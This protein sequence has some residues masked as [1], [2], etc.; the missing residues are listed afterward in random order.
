MF[1]VLL[2]FCFEMDWYNNTVYGIQTVTNIA[3]KELCAFLNVN[4]LPTIETK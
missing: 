3:H 2:F 1:F 4:S